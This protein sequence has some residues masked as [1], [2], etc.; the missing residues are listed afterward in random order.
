MEP[1]LKSFRL[2]LLPISLLYWV[3][4]RLRN[5]LYDRDYLKS[6]TFNFPLIG[7]G[8]LAVGG[9]GKT[10]MTEYLVRLLK[11]QYRVATLSRGYKRKTTGFGLAGSGTTALEIGDEPMLF[12]Q[13]FPDIA[14]AVGE[15]RL[16]A[17]P[18]L[19]HDRPE[20]QAILL[21]DVLQHRQVNPGLKILLTEYSNLYTRD[22][23]LPAGDLRDVRHS[24]RRADC[25][26]VT[27]CPPDLTLEKAASIRKELR[28]R[29]YQQVFFTCL[30]YGAIYRLGNPALQKGL[31]SDLNVLLVSGIANPKP[32]RQLLTLQA[33][34]YEWMG[35]PD[36]HI[37]T[38]DD[39]AEIKKQFAA[40]PSPA[41][42]LTTEKDAVRLEKFQ[43]DLAELPL[44]VIPV[45]PRFL[46]DEGRFQEQVLRFV[47]SFAP[48]N[49]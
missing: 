49:V 33:A 8:N 16:V 38:M 47:A 24:A 44:Y 17:I 29:M 40:M 45:Q 1:V 19:L 30:E 14:V 6:S 37:F 10:P 5:L 34:S 41:I 18:Q 7:I 22:F 43:G 48:V 28:P 3:V 13:K 26:V 31:T 9:T 12:H 27:K 36:H 23:M 4:V 35:Y 32:L 2:L 39:L 46:W 20:T 25:L 15:E 21:D 42:V 11:D